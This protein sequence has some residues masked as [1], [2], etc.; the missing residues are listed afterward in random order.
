LIVKLAYFFIS[1]YF[2]IVVNLIHQIS[3]SILPLNGRVLTPSLPY[4]MINKWLAITVLFTIKK[5]FRSLM[6]A[7]TSVKFVVLCMKQMIV[8]LLLSLIVADDGMA[9]TTA[10]K[11]FK[12]NV[13]AALAVPASNLKYSSIGAGVDV[14][15]QLGLNNYMVATAGVGYTGIAGKGFYPYTA[16]IPLT[17]GLRF[18]PHKKYYAAGKIGWGMYTLSTTNIAYTAYAF[19]GA[20][21]INKRWDTALYYDGFINKKTSFGYVS[22]RMGYCF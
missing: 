8:L 2:I 13:G 3:S 22:L 20:Y 6:L 19:G 9:Q 10:P 4:A 18:Y 17:A 11:G 7:T 16:A 1:N 12:V 5:G 21:V 14:Q 15:L